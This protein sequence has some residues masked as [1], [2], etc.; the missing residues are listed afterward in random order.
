MKRIWMA[1]LSAIFFTG[2]ATY[3]PSG[4]RTTSIED[5]DNA[6][7]EHQPVGYRFGY[8]EGC[9]SGY[10]SAGYSRYTFQKDVDRYAVDDIYKHGWDDGFK[11]CN[12][13]PSFSNY[14]SHYYYDWPGYYWRPRYYWGPRHHHRHHH[15][16]YRRRGC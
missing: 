14:S 7:G 10:V 8:K 1:V 5:V 6:V 12:R 15:R 16:H 3:S 9:D 4:P 2:C 11:A 13:K